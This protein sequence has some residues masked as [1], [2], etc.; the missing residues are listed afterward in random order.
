MFSLF[1]SS[2][3]SGWVVVSCSCVFV[4]AC[5]PARPGIMPVVDVATE[6]ESLTR[7]HAVKLVS[8][9]SCSVEE[10]GL[11]VGEAVGYGSVKSASRM[12]GAIVIFLD[13][14]TKVKDVVEK[15]VIIKDTFTRVLPLVDPAKKITISNAPPLH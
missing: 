12:N 3:I 2:S 6:F 8:A 1:F 14:R 5:L 7:R 4:V 9:V 13:N 11:A 10:A 15:G